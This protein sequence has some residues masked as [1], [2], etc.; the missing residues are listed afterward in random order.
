MPRA[1]VVHETG[2][3]EVLRFEDVPVPPAGPGE[4]LVRQ[5]AIGVNF[6][7]V[8]FRT[9]LYKA[10]TLPFVLG[11]EGAGVVEAVGPGVSEVRAGDRVAYAGVPGSYAEVRVMPAA[12]LVPLPPEIDER[13]AAAAMLKGM[14]AEF[15]LLRCGRVARGDTILFHAAAGGVG[16]IAAQ[17]ARHLGVH[18]IGTAGGPDKVRL[19]AARGCEHV[20]DYKTEDVVARVR[21]ITGGVGVSVVYDSVGKDTFA[22]SLD[23]LRRRGLLVVFGQSS[24]V[25]PPFELATLNAKGSLFL[26]RPSLFHYVV[27]REE[28][29][30][31]AQSLFDVVKSGAVKIPIGQTYPLAEAAAAHR[32]LEARRTTGSTIL[33]P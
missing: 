17:W 27:T 2:G 5:T 32:D 30:A 13:T 19:A 28:L 23:C 6:I 20:I 26:T 4:A 33:L 7:D 11:H 12:R 3:P 16:S 29:L 14:T 31:S 24:G 25:V 8:Y 9:G 22:T 15:L 10:P 18:V 1:I 21:E